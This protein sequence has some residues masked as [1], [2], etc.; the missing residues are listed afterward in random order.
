MIFQPYRS[1]TSSIR[2]ASSRVTAGLPNFSNCAV[3]CR[4]RCV[5]TRYQPV[6]IVAS[7]RSLATAFCHIRYQSEPT[8]RPV[9]SHRNSRFGFSTANDLR[10]LLRPSGLLNVP[11]SDAWT[12]VMPCPRPRAPPPAVCFTPA[13]KNVTVL[14]FENRPPYRFDLK[15]GNRS[16]AGRL[17]KVYS[18]SVRASLMC[19]A[20]SS[21]NAPLDPSCSAIHIDANGRQIV[22][23]PCWRPLPHLKS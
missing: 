22:L 16:F 6:K 4:M 2:L 8:L 11:T 7:S 13:D 10:K 15:V 17:L 1:S 20:V 18:T 3:F 12:I 14:P 9:D 21:K 5:G 23:M 19:W